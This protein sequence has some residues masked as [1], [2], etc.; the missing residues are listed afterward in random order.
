MENKKITIAFICCIL[1]LQIY[2]YPDEIRIK[3]DQITTSFEKKFMFFLYLKQNSKTPEIYNQAL[4]KVVKDH[5]SEMNSILEENQQYLDEDER[6]E[7]KSGTFLR[8][9][10]EQAKKTLAENEIYCLDN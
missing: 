2:A 6:M 4:C 8:K 10:T 9:T 5:T 7:V 3:M 1:P